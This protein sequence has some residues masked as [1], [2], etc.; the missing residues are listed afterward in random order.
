MDESRDRA[1][2]VDA[3]A[4]D[5]RGVTATVARADI[6]G[7]LASPDG[8]PELVGCNVRFDVVAERAGKLELV[9]DA[10]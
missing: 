6:E 2:L 8:P 3:T 7:V 5:G 10:F 1:R 4:F 9:P